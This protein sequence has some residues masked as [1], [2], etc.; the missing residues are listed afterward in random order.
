MIFSVSIFQYVTGSEYIQY[1]LIQFD[2]ENILNQ[3]LS[4]IY[5]VFG[6]YLELSETIL[7]NL[8]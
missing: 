8:E 1:F 6:Y 7:D 3:E 4:M 2:N 5:D